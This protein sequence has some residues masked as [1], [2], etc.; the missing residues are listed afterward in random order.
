MKVLYRISL[1]LA[2]TLCAVPACAQTYP[3][4]PIRMIVSIAA[5][6]LL[7]VSAPQRSPLS[8]DTPTFAEAGLGAYPGRGWWGLA[9]PKD[10]P[11]PIID[12]LNAE[13]I[14]LF[15]EAKFLAFLEKQ[16]VVAAPGSPAEFAAFIKND[17]QKAE[18]LIK[19][20]NTPRAE[21]RPQQQ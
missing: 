1:C 17:R 10:T 9:A 16:A 6:K 7:A 15:S 12:R 4:K 19:L 11:K 14:K 5:G 20:A 3:D 21:Y 2:A 8:P 18:S 13:F